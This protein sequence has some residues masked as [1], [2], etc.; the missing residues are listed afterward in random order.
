MTATPASA[1]PRQA[2]ASRLRPWRDAGAPALTDLGVTAGADGE[3][4]W[5]HGPEGPSWPVRV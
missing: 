4:V 3:C 2:C 1:D 5:A